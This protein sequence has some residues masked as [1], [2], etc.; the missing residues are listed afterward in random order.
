MTLCITGFT[1]TIAQAYIGIMAADDA[2]PD[3][4]DIYDIRKAPIDCDEYL[5]C[6]GVLVGK[7]I[8]E[9]TQEEID[10][11]M[12]VNFSDVAA[13][14]VKLFD[15]N[16]HAKVCIIGSASGVKGSYDMA[17]AGAKAA[18]HLYVESKRLTH[19]RQHLVCVAPTIISD[20]AMTERR[21]DL[22]D[23]MKRGRERRLGRWLRASE[24]AEI[25]YFAMHQPALCNTVI[26]AQGGN[27]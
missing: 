9:M 11:T 8:G 21:T 6:A 24:V 7:R 3:V 15:Y 4:V 12:S 5:L 17:Y 1:S 27:W 25:A 19:P 13:F 14:C 22:G 16:K 18:M 10:K 2:R 26:H 20:S 23:C